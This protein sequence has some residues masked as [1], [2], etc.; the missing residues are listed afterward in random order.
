MIFYVGGAFAFLFALGIGIYVIKNSKKF[1][2]RSFH[3]SGDAF[4]M[5]FWIWNYR[6]VGIW[7]IGFSVFILYMI[8]S[9]I[10]SS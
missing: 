7:F 2:E 5:S 1:G 10:F 9:S 8:F 4:N 3:S 6:V